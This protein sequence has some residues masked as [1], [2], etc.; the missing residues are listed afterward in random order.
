MSASRFDVHDAEIVALENHREAKE[1][2]LGL[3]MVGGARALLVF[4]G[5][6]SV[7]LGPFYDQNVLLA[8]YEWTAAHSGARARC[9]E[10]ELSVESTRAVLEGQVKFYELDPS[11]GLGGYI[12]ARDAVMTML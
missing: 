6:E 1:L 5:V 11:V 7:S 9:Q 8:L 3:R 2:S 4:S 10:F 12:L